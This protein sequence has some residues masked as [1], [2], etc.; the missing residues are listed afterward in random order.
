ME[1]NDG[2]ALKL[3]PHRGMDEVEMAHQHSQAV[4]EAPSER[5]WRFPYQ[6]KELFTFNTVD[7]DPTLHAAPLYFASDFSYALFSEGKPWMR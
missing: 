5:Y 6:C 7:L 4:M 1:M 3:T 2:A